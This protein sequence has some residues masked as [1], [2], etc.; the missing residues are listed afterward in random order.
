MPTIFTVRALVTACSKPALHAPRLDV[1]LEA[2]QAFAQRSPKNKAALDPWLFGALLKLSSQTGLLEN[3]LRVWGVMAEVNGVRPNTA[4]YGAYILACVKSNSEAGRAEAWA[5]FGRMRADPVA[6]PLNRRVAST[7]ITT[8]AKHHEVERC[9]EVLAALHEQG[10]EAEVD[11]PLAA[12]IMYVPRAGETG[13]LALT[14]RRCSCALM[15]AVALPWTRWRLRWRL[16]CL[17]RCRHRCAPARVFGSRVKSSLST[18]ASFALTPPLSYCARRPVCCPSPVP[19]YACVCS[20]DILRAVAVLRFIL[21]EGWEIAPRQRNELSRGFQLLFMRAS[22]TARAEEAAAGPRP[23]DQRAATVFMQNGFWVDLSGGGDGGGGGGLG[24]AVS[25]ARHAAAAGIDG[26]N[27]VLLNAQGAGGG[28]GE[29]ALRIHDEMRGGDVGATT[30]LLIEDYI[31]EIFDSVGN[32]RDMPERQRRQLHQLLYRS[33]IEAYCFSGGIV[34]AFDVFEQIQCSALELQG[35]S[36]A[37]VLQDIVECINEK[38]ICA[39]ASA[40][41]PQ[42]A[43]GLFED[44][45]DAFDFAE[46]GAVALAL[47]RMCLRCKQ[48]GLALLIDHELQEAGRVWGCID[49]GEQEEL[50]LQLG[51][52]A[53]EAAAQSGQRVATVVPWRPYQLKSPLM[54]SVITP[55]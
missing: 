9:F 41:A 47:L 29:Q 34:Q 55:F 15:L 12:Q 19:R 53:K 33:L 17:H 50:A 27:A 39:A 52:A 48:Y 28:A 43:F 44:A 11:Y 51:V 38:S 32:D 20:A 54:Q 21:L 35:S 5:S 36:E 45:A 37:E 4:V 2:V 46:G 13:G 6:L 40:A 24:G 26:G 23:G 3:A 25:E 22:E 31:G 1:A 18:V 42:R 7:L 16:R 30:S 8:C 49:E 14:T 10:Q